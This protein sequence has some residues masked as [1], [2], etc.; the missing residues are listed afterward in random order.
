M[1]LYFQ[2]SFDILNFQSR[3]PATEP[4]G[5]MPAMVQL[6]PRPQV[7]TKGRRIGPRP[8]RPAVEARILKTPW[9]S[10]SPLVS[11]PPPDILLQPQTILCSSLPSEVDYRTLGSCLFF[12]RGARPAWDEISI[13]VHTPFAFFPLFP[14]HGTVSD[15]SER[16]ELSVRISRDQE[17]AG[18][19]PYRTAGYGNHH[20]KRQYELSPRS[21]GS[22]SGSDSEQASPTP[23]YERNA[24]EVL[25]LAYH[26]RGRLPRV[27]RAL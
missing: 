26:S 2:L 9:H 22:Y 15:R 11:G 27:S 7:T 13:S 12:K 21:M 3:S 23:S 25:L 17:K 14:A 16:A 5:A 8:F 18:N 4:V 10:H 6:L 19:L 1:N 20:E 24:D